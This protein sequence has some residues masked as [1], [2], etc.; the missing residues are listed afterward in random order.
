MRRSCRCFRRR[1]AFRSGNSLRSGSWAGAHLR[2]GRP[3][4][5]VGDA[6]IAVVAGQRPATVVCAVNAGTA[7]R[8]RR[9]GHGWV[10]PDGGLV[11]AVWG[12]AGSPL[13]HRAVALGPRAGVGWW[14]RG[15]VGMRWL[16]VMMAVVA[17]G[18]APTLAEFNVPDQSCNVTLTTAGTSISGWRSL[19]GPCPS[20]D[21]IAGACRVQALNPDQPFL[22]G[23]D[24][25]TCRPTCPPDSFRITWLH[26]VLSG[27]AIVSHSELPTAAELPVEC[28]ACG[29]AE[30]CVRDLF[31]SEHIASCTSTG[32]FAV[33][34]AIVRPSLECQLSLESAAEGCAGVGPFRL[35]A[36]LVPR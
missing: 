1:S 35:R 20:H 9:F 14:R 7:P 31:G 16:L 2:R 26:S 5:D 32:K 22:P 8:V 24:F 19:C 18:C 25:V 36:S 33:D 10:V 6:R 34:P 28:S 21:V 27:G 30:V 11:V 15:E 29:I 4:P 3:G 12:A 17:A 13:G 23:R